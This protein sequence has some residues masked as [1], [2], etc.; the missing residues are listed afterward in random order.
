[1]LKTCPSGLDQLISAHQSGGSL[2]RPFYVD[3]DIFRW[4]V[5]RVFK[6]YWL[7]VAFSS[8]IP[9]PGDYFLYEI[10]G[11]QIIVVRDKDGRVHAHY[12]VCRHRGSR[13][14]L[15]HA[16]NKKKF[17]CPYHAWTFD[18]D[19]TFVN[20][21]H[22]CDDTDKRA[23][24]LFSIHARELEG[25]IFLCVGETAPD[26]EPIVRDFT[27]YVRPHGLKNSKV[28]CHIQFQIEANWKVVAENQWECYHCA[29]AHPELAHVMTYVRAHDSP[30]KALERLKFEEE[31]AAY[32]ESIGHMTGGVDATGP[33]AWYGARRVPIQPGFAVQTEDGKPAAPLMGDFTQYDGAVTGLNFYPLSFAVLN[34]DHA[35]L[36]RFTPI[37][38][39]KTDIELTWVV[40]EDAVE[41]V[42]YDV[43]RI[44]WLWESTGQA[45]ATICENNQK[46]VNSE[47]YQPGPHS[48]MEDRI[49]HMIHWYLR[50][51][52]HDPDRLPPYTPRSGKSSRQLHLLLAEAKQEGKPLARY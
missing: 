5:E 3:P 39:L 50:Q 13:L 18:H 23:L 31:W 27:P 7:P 14:C 17:V 11:E 9:R 41:G 24:G 43:D 35:V 25:L 45:D 34:N 6:R 15:E 33:D 37:D 48:K 46:G 16:G 20:G 38:T 49:D 52:A 42:D 32:A 2:A 10:A 8:R 30:S 22:L 47:R 51:I 19:G 40:R 29:P 26:F 36:L 44:K 28:C 4:D 12:N 21:R 1:M